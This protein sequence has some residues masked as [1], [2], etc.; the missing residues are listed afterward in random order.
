VRHRPTRC[1][2]CV[3][4]LKKEPVTAVERQVTEGERAYAEPEKRLP[5]LAMEL[6]EGTRFWDGT[7]QFRGERAKHFFAEKTGGYRPPS[8]IVKLLLSAYPEVVRVTRS[9]A[10]AGAC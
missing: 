6:F 5:E 7:A 10:G 1:G 9:E 3:K 8:R 4:S 2:H